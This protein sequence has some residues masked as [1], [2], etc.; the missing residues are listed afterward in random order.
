VVSTIK[1]G[2]PA[3]EYHAD[4][5]WISSSML[6]VFREDRIRFRDRF[7]YGLGGDEK[8]SRTILGTA[9]HMAILENEMYQRLAMAVPAEVLTKAGARSGNKYAAFAQQH[10]GKLLL[11]AKEIFAVEGMRSSVMDHPIA[12]RLVSQ[13]GPTEASLYWRCSRTGVH[14]RCR[15]DKLIPGWGFADLKSTH[16]ILAFRRL[17]QHMEYDLQAAFYAHGYEEHFGHKPLFSVIAVE[18]AAPHRCELFH[19]QGDGER[20]YEDLYALSICL[21]TGDWSNGQC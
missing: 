12:G 4:T 18:Q 3:D 19:F 7:E 8:N 21:Q 14:R 9:A 2:L 20:V 16:D 15:Y 10:T 11:H 17:V 6:S 13:P 5:E 1:L